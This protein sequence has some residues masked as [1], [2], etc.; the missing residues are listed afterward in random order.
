MLIRFVLRDMLIRFVLRDM[1]IRFVYL[2]FFVLDVGIAS[3]AVSASCLL[4]NRYVD[5][6]LSDLIFVF[7]GRKLGMYVTPFFKFVKSA[8][9]FPRQFKFSSKLVDFT[10]VSTIHYV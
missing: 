5:M 10:Y 6:V 8:L 2:L 3:L 1:L 4:S 7:S 9:P